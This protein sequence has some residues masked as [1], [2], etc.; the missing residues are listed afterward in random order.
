MYYLEWIV[1]RDQRSFISIINKKYIMINIF[2]AFGREKYEGYLI[3][4][5]FEDQHRLLT[6]EARISKP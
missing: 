5:F 6:D 1:I 2:P 3:C 4:P